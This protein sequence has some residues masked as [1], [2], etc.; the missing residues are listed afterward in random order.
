MLP[1]PIDG[2]ISM[3]L[4]FFLIPVDIIDTEWVKNEETGQDVQQYGEPRCLRVAVEPSSSKTME[5]I[6]GGSVEDG[7]IGIWTSE[8]LYMEETYEDGERKRQSFVDYEGHKYRISKI[9]QWRPQ[10]G[11]QV[12]LAKMHTKQELI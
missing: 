5:M 7:D 4:G 10:A 12:Y 11:I 9:G 6:F 3:A 8:C 1:Y 2:A